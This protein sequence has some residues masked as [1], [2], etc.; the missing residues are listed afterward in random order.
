MGLHVGVLVVVAVHVD[1]GELLHVVV[2]DVAVGVLAFVVSS[3]S[4]EVDPTTSH[5]S[6]CQDQR[7]RH[8]K[9]T[10]H[11]VAIHGDY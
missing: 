4:S 2:H 1:V 11:R 7:Q 9:E 5:Q 10:A 6:H 3:A 8:Y